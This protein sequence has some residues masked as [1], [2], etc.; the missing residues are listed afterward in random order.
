[1]KETFGILSHHS[2]NQPVSTKIFKNT[3]LIYN[4]LHN[5]GFELDRKNRFANFLLEN[6]KEIS[7]LKSGN[8]ACEK[9]NGGRFIANFVNFLK[10]L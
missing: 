3:N 2:I 10:K 7:L 8:T 1:M 4:N 5:S 6:V 9:Q